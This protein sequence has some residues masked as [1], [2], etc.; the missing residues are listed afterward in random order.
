MTMQPNPTAAPT[1]RTSGGFSGPAN[2]R[3]IS[4]V[5][6]L[7]F[8]LLAYGVYAWFT[9]PR[10]AA[11][12]DTPPELHVVIYTTPSCEPCNRAKTW[13]T[14]RQIAFEERNVEGSPTYEADLKAF[15]SRIV[16]VIVINGEPEFGFLPAHLEQI[17]KDA[18]RPRKK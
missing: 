16:P 8:A 4:L 1:R 6:L 11:E 15:K 9:K 5:G 18:T 12:P 7:V 10:A 3:G 17:I 14:Q 13:L 2:A